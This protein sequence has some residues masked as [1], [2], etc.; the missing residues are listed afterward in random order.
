MAEDTL[1]WC[2]AQRNAFF[3][4]CLDNYLVLSWTP[5]RKTISWILLAARKCIRDI[6]APQPKHFA[7]GDSTQLHSTGFSSS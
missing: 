3:K 4:F 1:G 2:V 7:S 5:T 6:L